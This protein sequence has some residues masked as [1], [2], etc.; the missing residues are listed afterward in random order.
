MLYNEEGGRSDYR[1]GDCCNSL[2]FL[3][4]FS[5]F[6]GKLNRKRYLCSTVSAFLE[7][8]ALALLF[9]IPS[10][11]CCAWLADSREREGV[12]G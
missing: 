1:C 11:T 10:N 4:F 2:T 9:K 7:V 5:I 6:F 8:S 3:M 12:K